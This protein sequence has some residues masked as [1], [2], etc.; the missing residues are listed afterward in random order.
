MVLGS[1][2]DLAALRRFA[3]GCEVVTFDHEHVPAGHLRALEADGVA[4]RPGPGA[5]GHAQDKG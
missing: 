4:L 5:L 2:T 3:A 1:H